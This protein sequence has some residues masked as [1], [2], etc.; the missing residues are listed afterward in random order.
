MTEVSVD[1]RVS[2]IG[3]GWV[4]TSVAIST[5]QSAAADQLWLH[6]LRAALAEG[7]A[8]DMSHGASF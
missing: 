7:E 3:C 4:G 8:M 6:D 1:R 5:L 2:I